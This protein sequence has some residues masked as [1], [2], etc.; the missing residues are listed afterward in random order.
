MR[1]LL[2]DL[3]GVLVDIV[4]GVLEH[5]KIDQKDVDAL[6]RP[7]SYGFFHDLSGVPAN[8]FWPNLSIRFWEE[9]D[10]TPFG[11]ELFAKVH[12]LYGENFC[13]ASDPSGS[14]FAII[15]KFL[16]I[17]KHLPP[18]F[19][20]RILL[21]RPKHFAANLNTILVDDYEKNV[22]VFGDHSGYAI[23]VPQLWNRLH[24][25]DP[26]QHVIPLLRE[27]R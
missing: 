19:E 3:D 10:W 23:L 17:K 7:L 6:P 15:G 21:G 14:D 22:K 11:R 12:E 4:K 27:L 2:L 9:L 18:G 8:G 25:L 26:I 16:W 13:L 1:K 5:L 20:H 24:D